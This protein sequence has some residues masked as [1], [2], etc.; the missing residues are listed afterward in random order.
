M[1]LDIIN[2]PP[3]TN[4]FSMTVTC[5]PCCAASSLADKTYRAGTDDDQVRLG[6]RV[7]VEDFCT[8]IALLVTR[9][10]STMIVIKMMV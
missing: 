6:D 3:N 9:K 1:P 5:T 2:V 10:T 7:D 4:L 8:T